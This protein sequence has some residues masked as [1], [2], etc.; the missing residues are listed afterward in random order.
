VQEIR[1]TGAR[2]SIK[3]IEI[4]EKQGDRSVMTITEVGA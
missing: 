4:I 1:F 2:S 3:T